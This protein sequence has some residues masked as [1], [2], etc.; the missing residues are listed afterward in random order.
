M[1]F[2]ELLKELKVDKGDLVYVHSS[3]SRMKRFNLK[4]DDII[5]ELIN[6]VGMD[7]TVVFPSFS[8]NIDPESRPW[9][10]YARYISTA[11]CFDVL[12]TKSNIGYLSE[13]FRN[14]LGVLRSAHPVWAISACGKMAKQLTENQEIVD[15]PYSLASSFGILKEHKVKIVGFGVTLNTT[16]LCP[17]VDFDL[18]SEHTQRVFTDRRIPAKV[19]NAN[20]EEMECATYTMLPEAVRYIKPIKVLEKSVELQ[21][22]L[23][24]LNINGD[25]YFSYYFEDYYR[26]AI[27]FGQEAVR[28]GRKMPWLDLL[29]LKQEIT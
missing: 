19:I 23:N 12:K 2:D 11:I 28:Q 18:G 20:G 8:W 5:T 6:T 1:K 29:P 7:G 22:R 9:K 21:R 24:F 10:G 25:F 13:C 27:G 4:P 3:Y 17:I 16:S 26:E 15:K 14:R